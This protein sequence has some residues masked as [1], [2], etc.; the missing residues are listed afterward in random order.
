MKIGK[1]V[2]FFLLISCL[3]FL[4]SCFHTEKRLYSKSYFDLFDTVTVIKGYE[5][6]EEDFLAVADSVYLQLRGYHMLFDIYYEYD[7]INNVC[8]LN[9]NAGKEIKVGDDMI[10]F[11]DFAVEMYDITDGKMNIAMGSVLS[12]WHRY[13]EE[14]AEEPENARIPSDEELREASLHTDIEKIRIDRENGSVILLDS[15]MSIDVGAVAKGYAAE[16]VAQ[17]LE[18]DGKDGYIISLGGN[19]RT[20]GSKPDGEEWILGIEDP[21]K[22]HSEEYLRRIKI[23]E[24]SLVTSGDYQRYYVV[25]GKKY[26]HIIDPDTL[27]PSEYFTLVTVCTKDS[28][29]A[30]ALSTALFNMPLDKGK[31]LAS[32][33]EDV[34]VL[35]LTK[36]GT[37]ICSDGMSGLIIK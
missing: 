8:T 36:D 3:L 30:D 4:A 15:E 37:V 7:G 33:L 29:F 14:A 28:G 26:N 10:D 21:Y 23:G 5:K 35:W 20:V 32:S 13:R 16:R 19:V 11:L 27:F 2:A 1:I 31:E 6:S 12:I 9:K 25:D 34:Y 24:T 18:S 17:T 22:E